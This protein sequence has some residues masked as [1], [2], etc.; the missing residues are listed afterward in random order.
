M[1]LFQ[2]EKAQIDEEQARLNSTM[3]T[4]EEVRSLGEN[5]NENLSLAAA[6][7]QADYFLRETCSHRSGR[8]DLPYEVAEEV[9]ILIKYEGYIKKQES[10][11][12]RFRRQEG[13]SIPKDLDW[14]K[15]PGLPSIEGRDKLAQLRPEQL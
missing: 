5:A 12:A 14:A 3:V 9:E 15:V 10:Q 7:A 11:V 13:R 1:L 2:Q 6:P 8:A 4:P